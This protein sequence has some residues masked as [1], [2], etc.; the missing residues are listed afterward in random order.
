MHPDYEVIWHGAIEDP[1]GY[2]RGLLLEPRA[3][4]SSLAA[5]THETLEGDTEAFQRAV[6]RFAAAVGPSKGWKRPIKQLS[7][8]ERVER[9]RLAGLARSR[10]WKAR[11]RALLAA[12]AGYRQRRQ[13]ARDLAGE[14]AA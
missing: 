13:M 4:R 9:A 12:D 1:H 3:E 8:E 6:N 5:I 14:G 11:R 10:A 2:G 7:H